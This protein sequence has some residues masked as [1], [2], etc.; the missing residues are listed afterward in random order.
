V[1]GL[2]FRFDAMRREV[3]GFS[4]I[5]KD[6]LAPSAEACLQVLADQLGIIQLKA[7]IGRN[8]PAAQA[9]P[10]RWSIPDHQPLLTRPSKAYEKGKKKGGPLICAR[11]TSLWEIL[12]EPKR[13]KYDV[14]K[15]FY[16]SGIAS[17]RIEWVDTKD[18]KS[19]GSWRMEIADDAS[20]GCYFHAQILGDYE[21]PPF[22]RSLPVPRL[23]CIASTPMAV[24]EFVL[25]ELFQ[26][27]WEAHSQ[28]PSPEMDNWRSTQR[29]RLLNLLTWQQD[30][31]KD[32]VFP[33]WTTLKSARPSQNVLHKNHD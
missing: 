2:V 31:V 14:S 25:G 9:R 20:P 5:A 15:H 3:M 12:P 10:Y 21:H 27:E 13:N 26:D 4:A 29:H 33:P 24:L 16:I 30:L 17:V 28:N 18:H 22:P 32:C 11:V 1:T 8:D 23:P 6:F 7:P 19:L